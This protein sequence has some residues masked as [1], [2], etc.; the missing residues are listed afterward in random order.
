[1][2]AFPPSWQTPPRRFKWVGLI[3]FLT[4][5]FLTGLLLFVVPAYAQDID[6]VI[7]GLDRDF[8][9]GG[10]EDIKQKNLSNT[11]EALR[12]DNSI[13]RST[14][15]GLVDVE[16]FIKEYDIDTESILV[17]V[18]GQGT[19]ASMVNG[20][21]TT[22]SIQ[23]EPNST[24]TLKVT[25][26]GVMFGGCEFY[27]FII[28]GAIFIPSQLADTGNVPPFLGVGNM[29]TFQFKVSADNSAPA[30]PIPTPPPS[31]AM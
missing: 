23:L 26:Q 28:K 29:A 2:R 27:I 24:H 12:E 15:P 30:R 25:C 16:F 31:N 3:Q 13:T 10:K 17:E 20:T 22:G 14:T 4:L 9:F 5:T 7:G 18:V 11:N 21:T 6:D 8:V 1:M 19:I